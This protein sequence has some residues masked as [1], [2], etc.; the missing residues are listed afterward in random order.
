M[1]AS[2]LKHDTEVFLPGDL[3]YKLCL[4]RDKL[5]KAAIE[6]NNIV[7]TWLINDYLDCL[8]NTVNKLRVII[9]RSALICKQQLS[10]SMEYNI[11][12]LVK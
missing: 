4:A 3:K 5:V 11:Q 10:V 12:V 1:F 9:L 8:D 2:V 7:T 6:V